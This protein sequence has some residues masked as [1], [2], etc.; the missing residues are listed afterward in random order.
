MELEH[1]ILEKYDSNN[2]YHKS[3]VIL[4]G[5]DNAVWEYLGDLDIMIEEIENKSKK[6]PY[7]NFFIAYQRGAVEPFGVIALTFFE[8]TNTYGMMYG[9]LPKY[10]G[11]KLSIA[12]LTE[13]SES[14]LQKYQEIEEIS[15][16]INKRNIFS[17]KTA[18]HSGFKR[19]V[20]TKYVKKR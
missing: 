9:I 5:N 20:G 8:K 16:Q 2:Y 15:L 13:F 6:N 19:S 12:L 10:R 11:Q 18:L 1:F 4:L 3:T 14:I 17:I 7:D